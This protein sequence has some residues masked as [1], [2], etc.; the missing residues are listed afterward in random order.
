MR[1]VV[2]SATMMWKC[3]HLVYV[4]S[5]CMKFRNLIDDDEWKQ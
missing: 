4:F 1:V 3:L 5:L 2:F